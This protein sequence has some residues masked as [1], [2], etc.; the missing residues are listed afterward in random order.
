MA[1]K[2]GFKQQRF[3][4]QCKGLK[5]NTIHKF[6]YEGVDRGQDCIPQY[7]KPSGGASV[8][9][10]SALVTDSRGEIRFDF[11]FTLDV[12][13]QVDASNKVK[14]EVAGNKRFELRAENSTAYKIVPFKDDRKN[15]RK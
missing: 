4:I 3:E 8:T 9:P 13:K 5:P 10:G 1:N 15:D 2:K 7:P 6:Y 14:Y 12:E 11:L